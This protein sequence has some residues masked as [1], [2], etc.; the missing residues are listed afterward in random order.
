[1]RKSKKEKEKDKPDERSEREGKVREN[2]GV[3]CEIPT[4]YYAISSS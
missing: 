2:L 1:L 3:A 4:P